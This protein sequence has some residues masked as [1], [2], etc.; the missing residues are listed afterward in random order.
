MAS[1][2]RPHSDRIKVRLLD[3][4]LRDLFEWLSLVPILAEE[5]AGRRRPGLRQCC[6]G[7]GG[8]DAYSNCRQL[9]HDFQKINFSAN[10]MI[11]LLFRV[12]ATCPA[13]P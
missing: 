1:R 6:C 7:R 8:R 10:S 4:L 3:V 13:D 2:P 9:V 5:E 12:A 11:R